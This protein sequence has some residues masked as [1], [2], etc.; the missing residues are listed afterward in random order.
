MLKGNPLILQRLDELI[1]EGERI[2]TNSRKLEQG[3][4]MIQCPLG[5]G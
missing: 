3:Q 5:V 4:L 1:A 2:L